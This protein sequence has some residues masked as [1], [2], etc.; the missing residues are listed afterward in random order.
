MIKHYNFVHFSG[1]PP[2]SEFHNEL[3]D[4]ALS[5]S[6]YIHVQAVWE[7]FNMECLGDLHDLWVTHYDCKY[8]RF[9]WNLGLIH[10]FTLQSMKYE[11]LF[12]E[13]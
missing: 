3:T 7:E 12:V 11:I 13:L 9:N 10:K 1:L 6:D 8:F 2:Q 4:E 5:D